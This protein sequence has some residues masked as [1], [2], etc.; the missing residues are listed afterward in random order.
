MKELANSGVKYNPD[1][2]VIITKTPDGKLLWLKNGNSSDGL[3][4]I[5]DGKAINYLDRGISVDGIPYFLE[6]TLKTTPFN[7]GTGA[8]GPFAVYVMNG[9]NYRVAYGLNGYIISLFPID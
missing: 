6:Q 8:N 1:D 9:K 2:V 7:T 4:H 5:I 3:K